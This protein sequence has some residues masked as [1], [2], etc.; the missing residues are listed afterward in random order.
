MVGSGRL[1]DMSMHDRLMRWLRYAAVAGI[2]GLALWN[3]NSLV[4]GEIGT[5]FVPRQIV[6]EYYRYREF[7]NIQPEYFRVLAVPVP[8]KWMVYTNLHPK[9][10][11]V[12]MMRGDWSGFSLP[13][14]DGHPERNE[15]K[16]I[17]A[18]EQGFSDRLLDVSAIRYVVVP[19][20]DP[21]N[22]DDFFGAYG[23]RDILLSHLD[24]LPYLRRLET[25]TGDVV[26]FENAD[27]RP[28]LYATAEP[29]TMTAAVPMSEVSYE[30]VSPS[31]Y[32][33]RIP[34]EA[35]PAE[36]D[37]AWLDFSEAYHPDWKIRLG[38]FSW[39]ESL[40][41]PGY[42]VDDSAHIRTDA[43]LNAFRIPKPTDGEA[44]ELTVFFRPQ[45]HLYLGLIVSGAVLAACLGFL[46]W[47]FARKGR[48]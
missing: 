45:A 16:L 4:T 22:A 7:I 10:S 14:M 3:A 17:S 44:V 37:A 19:R 11:M 9:A 15:R 41:S 21:E 36:G 6:P 43:G 26:V 31:E 5:M 8:S 40:R 47:A 28:H 46:G 27:A 29:D 20:D 1:M 13:S 39:W 25:G 32:R 48:M 38:G 33:V 34:A 30:A 23:D 18:L 35:F 24:A 2:A 42:F 12:D